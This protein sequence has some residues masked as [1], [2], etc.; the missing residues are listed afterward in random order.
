MTSAFVVIRWMRPF[1]S[2]NDGRAYGGSNDDHH[3]HHTTTTKPPIGAQGTD[4]ARGL[5]PGGPAGARSAYNA[6][7][8]NSRW[9]RSACT[10]PPREFKRAP[11]GAMRLGVTTELEKSLQESVS[12]TSHTH[13]MDELMVTSTVVPMSTRDDQRHGPDHTT[14]TK[15]P[16]SV[17]EASRRA[18]TRPLALGA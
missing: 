15:L 13:S 10:Y 18:H 1:D 11:G 6:A 2:S 16:K 17:P 8:R 5:A 14:K 3:P 12:Q 9:S 7:Q 4:F